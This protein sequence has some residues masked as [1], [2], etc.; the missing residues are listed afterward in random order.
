MGNDDKD[1]QPA[2]QRP[3]CDTF[4]SLLFVFSS[5]V[6]VFGVMSSSCC[7]HINGGSVVLAYLFHFAFLLLLCRAECRDQRDAVGSAPYRLL[8]VLCISRDRLRSRNKLVNHRV[9]SAEKC[10]IA[11]WCITRIT[12]KLPA[13]YFL[14]TGRSTELD[15]DQAFV[16]HHISESAISDCTN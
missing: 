16:A 9:V 10:F 7:S 15:R 8:L 3:S 5:R 12:H 1:G 4:C 6:L 2:A 14:P 11:H 13:T